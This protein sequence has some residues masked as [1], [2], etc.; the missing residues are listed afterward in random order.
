MRAARALVL[1]LAA[2]PLAG[3]A[4]QADHAAGT[5]EGEPPSATERFRRW[6]EATPGEPMPAAVTFAR[7]LSF[8]EVEGFAREHGLRP[9]AVHVRLAGSRF[10]P[11]RG[12]GDASLE[13]VAEA[14]RETLAAALRMVCDR[15]GTAAR[16]DAG[17]GGAS[18]RHPGLP[19]AML[20]HLLASRRSLRALQADSPTV[21]GLEVVGPVTALEALTRDE[22]V[23]AVEPRTRVRIRGV[24]RLVGPAP[25]DAGSSDAPTA[26]GVSDAEARR[27]LGEMDEAE[28]ESCR[29]WEARQQLLREEGLR[30]R[31]RN[32]PPD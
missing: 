12:P 10:A 17:A 11:W 22:R 23:S 28:R 32:P 8:D 19:Q 5:P 3:C 27:L 15:G 24:E 30:T 20:A 13:M 14:R 31:S 9:F 6:R 21:F 1:L 16:L 4:G 25:V 7:D 29:A 26:A 18:D 2:L